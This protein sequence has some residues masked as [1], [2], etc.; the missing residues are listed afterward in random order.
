MHLIFVTSLVIIL[1]SCYCSAFDSNSYA[2]ALEK[3]I[4]FFEGQRSGKLPPNQRVTWRGDSGLK[5]GS[6]EN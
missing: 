6:T 1:F 3:S 4:M 5:D 2:D